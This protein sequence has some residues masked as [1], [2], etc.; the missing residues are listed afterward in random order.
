MAEQ[1]RTV[2]TSAN[3]QGWTP[4]GG[5]GATILMVDD[6]TFVESSPT[7]NTASGT[8]ALASS[9]TIPTTAVIQ[10]VVV[11]A[12]MRLATAGVRIIRGGFS[13][14]QAGAQQ[15]LTS[16]EW[17]YV[18]FAM[19]N[20][21]STSA[22][23]TAEG[24]NGISSAYIRAY[25]DADGPVVHTGY[26]AIVVE[27]TDEIEPEQPEPSRMPGIEQVYLGGTPVAKAYA[28]D[29]L[30]WPAESAE[31]R[32]MVSGTSFSPEI[33]LRSSSTATVVWES[34]GSTLGGTSVA[35]ILSWPDAG[36]HLVRA[37]ISKRSHLTT[38]NLGFSSTDDV[39][40]FGPGISYDHPAQPV[41]EIS[42]L[43]GLTGLKRF[44]AANGPLAGTLDLSGCSALEFVECFE[45]NLNT[46]KLTD[47][48]SL[49]RLCV[50]GNNIPILDLNPVRATLRDLRAAAQRGGVIEFSPIA[51]QLA[52]LYHFCVRGQELVATPSLS[53]MPVVEQ[54]WVWGCGIVSPGTPTS[55]LL[56]SCLAHN[57]DMPESVVDEVLAHINANV[58]AANGNV[59]LDGNAAPSSVGEAAANALITRGGWTVQTAIGS[60]GSEPE[61]PQ[62]IDTATFTAA[63]GKRTIFGHQSVGMQVLQGVSMLAGQLGVSNPS[64]PDYEATT[65]P[66]SGG[67]LAHF[68]AGSN[69]NPFS[70]LDEFEAHLR[71]GLAAQVDIVVLKFCYAD[72]R[73]SSSH[74]PQQM[75]DAYKIWCD[76]IETDFPTLTIIYATEAIVMGENSDGVHNARRQVF[77]NLIR[78][79]YASTGRLWDVAN[80]QSTDPIGNK[81]LHGGIE[82]LY[83]GYASPDQRHIYGPGRTALAGPLL[84]LIANV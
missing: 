22:P 41:T 29:T 31:L 63:M 60:G 52:A 56:N 49:I 32:M 83:S 50:E 3:L 12:K 44:L 47:C 15:N 28:G 26:L 72:L 33:E 37:L 18:D 5:A 10:S 21:P 48:T 77:N 27:Y 74:T 11:R 6:T 2:S 30:I 16:A 69:G 62:Q 84:Q 78:A 14:S 35:P 65:L 66:S 46:I 51:G 55:P 43:E 7:A 59:R 76:T 67:M 4:S 19:P 81:I 23:W 75:F 58:P 73:N 42:G 70:K 80:I 79:E 45:A 54:W 9:F 25:A 8:L 82:S 71:G 13:G 17:V 24:A 38:I 39:G 40:R 1:V 61:P 36:P 57:N 34:A 68:Y 53:Q 64:F 20:D